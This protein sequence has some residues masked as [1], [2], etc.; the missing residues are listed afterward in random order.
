VQKAHHPVCPRRSGARTPHHHPADQ[1]AAHNR[2]G[3][4][5]RHA[6]ARLRGNKSTIESRRIRVDHMTV[7]VDS[8]RGSG[9]RVKRP[10]SRRR[11]LH[12]CAA[13]PGLL[14]RR[15]TALARHE[16]VFYARNTVYICT[17]CAARMCA[18]LPLSGRVAS[19]RAAMRAGRVPARHMWDLDRRTR[20]R[21]STYR[22]FPAPVR[23]T[24]GVPRRTLLSG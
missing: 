2:P 24:P 14:T 6:D 5:L 15:S 11:I 18:D 7:V 17:R 23:L 3:D 12:L 10:G 16:S 21:R 4:A 1:G 19:D 9:R 22:P 20:V 8:P 13:S